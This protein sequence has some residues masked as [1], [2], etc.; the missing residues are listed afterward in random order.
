MKSNLIF[1]LLLSGGN[2]GN[3]T[4]CLQHS[5]NNYFPSFNNTYIIKLTFNNLITCF[6]TTSYELNTTYFILILIY[7]VLSIDFNKQICESSIFNL[8]QRLNRLKMRCAASLISLDWPTGLGWGCYKTTEG[9]K[10]FHFTVVLGPKFVGH[11]K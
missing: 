7:V 5:F 2:P 3:D 9:L 11:A 10:N 8:L 4:N 1:E 6:I